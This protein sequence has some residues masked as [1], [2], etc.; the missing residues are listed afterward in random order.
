[1]V[2]YAGQ[3]DPRRSMSLLWRDAG[4]A[5][6]TGPG[7][8][9]GLSV[10]LVVDTAIELADA[11]GM[12]ALS[13]RA[14][15]ERL[16]RT[17]MALYTYVPGKNELIDLMYDRA[18]AELPTDYPADQGWRSA[19]TAWAD[20]LWRFYLRHPW[21]LQVSQARPVLGPNEYGVLEALVRVLDGTGLA[22]GEL[23]RV[24]G[25][26]FHV[27]RGAAQTI[28]ESRHAA[29]ATGVSDEEWWFARAGVLREV[30]P[31]FA[32]RF[33]MVLRLEA[34]QA[35]GWEDDGSPYLER[36]AK[37]TFEAGLAVVLDGIEAAMARTQRDRAR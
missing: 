10:D 5:E 3:G 30:A 9:P 12:P 16:G 23:R 20:D 34:D 17:A 29:A 18:L 22:A 33:P 19:V 35:A 13:M 1:M 21:V 37:R 11:E 32:E 36:E 28:A 14:V 2:V 25:T 27:V 26:L 6:R 4:T 8:K 15:G 7:P 24:V 31:D